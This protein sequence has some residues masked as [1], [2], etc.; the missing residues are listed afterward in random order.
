MKHL[1]II[2]ILLLSTC[3]AN[4]V[5]RVKLSGNSY[6]MGKQWAEEQGGLIGSLSA[7]FNL[8]AALYVNED[9]GDLQ[10]MSLKIAQKMAKEDLDEIR[11]IAD[12]LGRTYEE[13]LTFN[14]FYTICV[15]NIACRQFAVWG[16][17]SKD[18][19]LYHA[20]NLDWVDYPGNPL[21]KHNTI[22]N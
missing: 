14:L 21:Q 16:D 13:I 15:S 5:E 8:M 2:F 20:R 3:L 18:G 17:K 12:G 9:L 6:E 4:A 19:E 7:Q 10:K 11:G 1:F 22:V